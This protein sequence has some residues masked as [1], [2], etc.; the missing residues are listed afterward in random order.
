MPTL[1]TTHLQFKE[2]DLVSVDYSLKK[3]IKVSAKPTPS[4]LCITSFLPRECGIATY[5]D[6]LVKA[7]RTQFGNSLAISI[8]PLESNAEMHVYNE[9]TKYSLH[10]DQP[11]NFASLAYKINKDE[12]VAQVLIQHEFG[13]FQNRETDL[14]LFVSTLEKPVS[15]V[16]HTVLPNANPAH[17]AH[18]RKLA[19]S[20]SSVVVLTKSSANLLIHQYHIPEKKV[21]VIA[22][23]T[24]LVPHANKSLLKEKY[25]LTGKVVLSTFGLLSEGKSIE[26]TLAALPTIVAQHPDVMFLIIGKTHPSVAKR[27]GEKYRQMLEKQI[28]DLEMAHHV[29]F[30]N[31]FLPL[32]EL[33][34]YLQL[35]DVYLFTS[36]DPNQA[37]SGTFSYAFSCGCPI[38]STPIP[39][40]VEV[41]KNDAGIIF[42][43]GD[44]KQLAKAV[45]NLVSDEAK[46]QD[47]SFN[48]LQIMASTA[49]Q[50]AAIAHAGL[51]A[52]QG[53][54]LFSPKYQLPP[55]NLEHFHRLTTLFGMIQFSKVNQPDIDSGYTIDDNARAMVALCQYYEITLDQNA[56]PLIYIYLEFIRFCQQ[57]DGQFLNYVDEHNNFTVQN[58]ETNLEDSNGRTVW[59]LG[60][61]ISINHLLPTHLGLLAISLYQKSMAHA[62]KMHSTRAI[63]FSI[64]GLYYRGKKHRTEHNQVLM[65]ELANRL[66]QMFRHES[67]PGWRWFESY[68]TYANSTL[69]EAMLCAWMVTG[70]TVYKEI[71]IE[72]FQ[73]LLDQIFVDGSIKVVSNKHWSN[74]LPL[75]ENPVGGEQPIDVAYT[76]MALAKFYE[77]T[78][79]NMYKE[80]MCEAFNWFLGDNHLKQI[81]YNPVTGGCYDGLEEHN[82]NLNQGAESTVSYLMARLT[83]EKVNRKATQKNGL[84]IVQST[85]VVE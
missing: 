83:L 16:F 80:K 76:V 26:T 55:I 78:G 63:A 74:V 29:R 32:S 51:F 81:I 69:P 84:H 5:S 12:N 57:A 38:V 30:V 72:S 25:N 22:H 79:N 67:K 28:N 56:L 48:A 7:L 71:A 50:N 8:C 33:L 61:L 49:W 31:A 34:E 54:H 14:E 43:F 59:A 82:V 23:G 64:K 58:F 85:V 65:K 62:Q 37:V 77:A 17:L 66:V 47:I 70:E 21:N 60:Y 4:V 6:D 46:R 42:D 19:A 35:T 2:R 52:S 75:E 36:K 73:F 1:R 3:A 24:H 44:S 20:C 27:E 45:I 9:P 41:L 39:H 10:V 18:V 53:G 15:M 13:F 40:A 68:L 11:F